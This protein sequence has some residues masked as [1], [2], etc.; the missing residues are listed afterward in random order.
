MTRENVVQVIGVIVALGTLIVTIL[1]I[2][3]LF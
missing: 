1:A 2:A 3:H